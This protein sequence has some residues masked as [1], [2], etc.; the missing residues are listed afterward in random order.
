VYSPSNYNPKMKREP[1]IS[2]PIDSSKYSN[3]K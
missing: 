3:E 2:K 1:E